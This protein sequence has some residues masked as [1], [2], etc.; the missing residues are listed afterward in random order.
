ME[1]NKEKIISE[2][3][4][5]FTQIPPPPKS[6]VRRRLIALKASTQETTLKEVR[7]HYKKGL[8]HFDGWLK[9]H[10]PKQ[11]KSNSHK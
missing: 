9:H 7:E 1:K 5:D 4:R 10:N 3:V 2:M 6:Q 11:A 8:D